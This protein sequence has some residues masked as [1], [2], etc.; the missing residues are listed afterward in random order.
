MKFSKFTAG[1]ASGFVL[2]LLLAPQKGKDT[3]KQ[4]KDTAEAWKNKLSNLF[5]KGESELD[6]LKDILESEAT[7]LNQELRGRL[8]K[9]I[10][11]NRQTYQEAKHHSLS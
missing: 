4:V 5:G 11:E 9:I 8:L 10:E 3:R 6:E 1:I 2:G 7:E